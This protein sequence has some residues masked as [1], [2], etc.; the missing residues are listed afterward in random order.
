MTWHSALEK[1]KSMLGIGDDQR[2]VSLEIKLNA[3]LFAGKRPDYYRFLADLLKGTKGKRSLMDIFTSDAERYGSTARGKLSAHWAKMF[4]QGGGSL[5]HTFTGTLPQQDAEAMHALLRAGGENALELALRD[6]AD[7]SQVQR[8][9]L[10]IILA[11]CISALFAMG[12]LVTFVLMYP[13]YIVPEI[14]SAFTMLPHD[15]YPSSAVSMLKY[16]KFISDYWPMIL[17]LGVGFVSLCAW[18]FPN[19]TGKVRIAFDKY[20]F[21]WSIH[22]DFES[23]RFLSFLATMLSGVGSSHIVLRDALEMQLKGASRWKRHHVQLMVERVESG[24]VGPFVFST[25]FLERSMDFYLA[26]LIDANGLE[27]A[28]KQV[29]ERLSEDVL[30]RISRQSVFISWVIILS[31]LFATT[32]LML[33]QAMVVDDMRKALQLFVS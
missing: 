17:V 15:L 5:K 10:D 33:W 24:Q 19:L 32:V 29:K 11:T 6:L 12:I 4:D 16:T 28:L 2:D 21:L 3:L 27:N 22:R 30:R 1:I 20:G 8:K 31:V 9:A 7:S 25:G 14:M 23:I 18:S 13:I 26:D